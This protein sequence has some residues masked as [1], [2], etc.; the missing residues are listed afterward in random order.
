MDTRE[1]EEHYKRILNNVLDVLEGGDVALDL[2]DMPSAVTTIRIIADIAG[3]AKKNLVAT[4]ELIDALH[5]KV[6]AVYDRR[7][8]EDKGVL[9]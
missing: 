2:E 6:D 5:R 1:Q 8:Q 3:N 4:R 7:E 9:K